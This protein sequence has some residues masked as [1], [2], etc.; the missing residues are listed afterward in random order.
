MSRLPEIDSRAADSHY[1]AAQRVISS[2]RPSPVSVDFR[3]E[4]FCRKAAL[5]CIRSSRRTNKGGLQFS[6]DV[7]RHHAYLSLSGTGNAP[8]RNLVSIRVYSRNDF[9]LGCHRV[10]PDVSRA[11]Q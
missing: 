7:T 2:S 9:N 8:R 3:I 6:Q 5:T 1:G 4:A 10:Y 11:D